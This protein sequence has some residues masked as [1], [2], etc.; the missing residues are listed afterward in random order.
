M[1]LFVI[2]GI[3]VIVKK[4]VFITRKWK[5]TGDAAVQFGIAMIAAPI[6]LVSASRTVLPSI[7]PIHILQHPIIGRLVSIALLAI[8]LLIVA[9][10]LRDK[11]AQNVES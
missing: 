5:L 8:V 3:V 4:R 2:F 6:G 10:L 11:P 9:F 1:L 7:V